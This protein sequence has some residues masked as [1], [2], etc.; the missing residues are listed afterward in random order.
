[1]E[2]QPD[3]VTNNMNIMGNTSSG[4]LIE[5]IVSLMDDSGGG[6]DMWKGGRSR[7]WRP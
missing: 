5:L 4:M 6:G 3:K 1:M 7:S 2:K